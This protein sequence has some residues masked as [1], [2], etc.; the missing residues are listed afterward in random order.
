M[1]M[2][3]LRASVLGTLAVIIGLSTL[4][5]TVLL[6]LTG[7]FSIATLVI[8][9]IVFNIIQ[10]LLAPYIIDA[11]YRAKEVSESDNPELCRMVKRLSE[12]SGIAKPKVMKADI[13]VPNAFAYGSPVAGSRVA[14]TTGL[15]KTLE[16]EDPIVHLLLAQLY[17]ERCQQ[18]DQQRYFDEKERY[19]HKMLSE[20]KWSEAKVQSNK[21]RLTCEQ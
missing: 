4:F 6:S 15:L 16:P 1:N 20:G 7:A 14:V 13:P 12:K 2:W 3:K 9:V 17:N 18:G 8:F 19:M 11:L 21:L 5:F 10:W